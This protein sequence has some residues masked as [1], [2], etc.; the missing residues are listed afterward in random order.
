MEGPYDRTL[1]EDDGAGG[2][3]AAGERRSDVSSGQ[4]TPGGGERYF[5]LLHRVGD[6]GCP[7]GQEAVNRFIKTGGV[8][9]NRF[10]T[11]QGNPV[12]A[13]LGCSDFDAIAKQ[14]RKDDGYKTLYNIPDEPKTTGVHPFVHTIARKSINR[15]NVEGGV[16][17]SVSW[18]YTSP[19]YKI[20]INEMASPEELVFRVPEW[21]LR[22]NA[23]WCIEWIPQTSIKAYH[24]WAFL[25]A[26]AM[27]N[28]FHI[29]KPDPP[30]TI[31][32]LTNQQV[33]QII[34]D[35]HM[36]ADPTSCTETP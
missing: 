23:S 31:S 24:V 13:L 8:G 16:M 34:Y 36:E 17:R 1:I 18:F 7:S 27:P 22:R 11:I 35:A 21:W 28:E 6:M 5:Y 14:L 29:T 32:E 3:A 30:G 26:L 19:R 15:Q 10:T 25:T 12:Y 20:P 9:A 2:A 4:F 33:G